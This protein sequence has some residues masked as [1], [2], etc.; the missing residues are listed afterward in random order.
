[1][2]NTVARPFYDLGVS[3]ANT[4]FHPNYYGG[5]WYVT[6]GN[7]KKVCRNYTTA[8]AWVKWAHRNFKRINVTHG[9]NSYD[10]LK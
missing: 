2:S 7:K 5:E 1:M 8:L 6:I 4:V 10:D 9:R 3:I